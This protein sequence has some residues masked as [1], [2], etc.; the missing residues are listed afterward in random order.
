MENFS[1]VAEK[2]QVQHIAP[3]TLV[4]PANRRAIGD[5]ITDPIAI[6]AV[7]DTIAGLT[8]TE[9]LLF[10]CAIETPGFGRAFHLSREN[11]YAHVP[12]SSF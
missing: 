2:R 4:W 11:K 7:G 10:L 9:A 6:R 12:F 8:A 1:S 3:T 5:A